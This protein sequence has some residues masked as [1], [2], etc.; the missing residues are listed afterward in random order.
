MEQQGAGA[1]VAP[2][3][4][5]TPTRDDLVVLVPAHDEQDAIGGTLRA[6]ARQTVAPGRV[7]VVAD[8]CTDATEDVAAAHGAQVL[9]TVGNA[10]RKAGALDQALEHLPCDGP[11]Y[12]LVLDADTRLAPRFVETALALLDADAGLGAVS[13]IFTGEEPRGYLQRCQANEYVRY[14]G[15][16]LTTRRVAVVTGTA[17]VFRLTALRDV[18]GAR[19]GALPGV[20][21]DVYDR[22]A[23][24]EDSELTLALK[25][26][27]WRLAAPAAARCRTELM[28]TWGDLHRQR[29]RWYK[30]M[31]DNLREYGLTRV[32][33]RYVGQQVMIALGT[34]TL[35]VLLVLTAVSA[36]AGT[37][38]LQPFW[39]A[40][41]GVFVVE[42]VVTVAEADARGRLLALTVVPELVYAIALQVAFVHALALAL[43]RRDTAWNHVVATSAAG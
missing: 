31:L 25:T 5:R 36:V 30:G 6:L 15:Q 9:P 43:A 16:I 41:G 34:A 35:A 27:G 19:G 38:A 1:V 17:S 32:T 10:H 7:V 29:V 24:T 2:R 39:L 22:S 23:I 18:A 4:G 12:V 13:G 33:A 11:R 3:V 37:F 21:G 8:R 42:R 14:R 28:P 26:R 20:R 40:V